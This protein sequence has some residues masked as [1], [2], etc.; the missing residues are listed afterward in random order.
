MRTKKVLL[1]GLLLVALLATGCK[2]TRPPVTEVEGRLLLNN[3]PLPKA[4]VR[5]MPELTDW[6]A[7]MNSWAIT[8][9]QGHFK[10]TCLWGDQPGAAVAMHRVV[11][12]DPPV[13]DNMRD[14]DQASQERLSRHLASLK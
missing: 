12:T 5:F 7:D 2:K 14:Q 11:V 9:D 1:L 10:L 4:Y 3:Q 8:D 6:G 13:E